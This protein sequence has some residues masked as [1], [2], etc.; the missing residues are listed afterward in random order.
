MG[1]VIHCVPQY[2]YWILFFRYFLKCK[3]LSKYGHSWK[4][5]QY[6][7]NSTWTITIIS[8]YPCDLLQ[9]IIAI[10]KMFSLV[11]LSF[12]RVRDWIRRKHD[13]H[14]TVGPWLW[15]ISG[16]INTRVCIWSSFSSDVSSKFQGYCNW[17]ILTLHLESGH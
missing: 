14:R 6:Y 17:K 13:I 1:R 9:F 2:L 8:Q 11:I 16:N 15:L 3:A 7:W 12:F 10:V 5:S 4:L